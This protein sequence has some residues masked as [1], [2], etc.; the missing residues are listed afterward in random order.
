MLRGIDLFSGAGGLSMGMQAAGIN[1]VAAVEREQDAIRTL[2]NHLPEADLHRDDIRNIDLSRYKGAIDLVIG[3]PPC[4]PFSSGGLRAGANDERDMIPHFVQAVATLKPKAFLMENVRGLIVKERRH[5]FDDLLSDFFSLGYNV[6]WQILNAADYGVPQKRIRLFI[7]GLLQGSFSFPKPSHGLDRNFSYT[8]VQDALPLEQV[9]EPN[10]A[11]VTYA[12]T[13][14]VRPS[15]YH[16][17]LFNGG[18]RPLNREQP[19]PT[20]LASAGGNKTHFIDTENLVLPYHNHL[21]SGGSP[22]CGTLLG[23]RRLTIAES[24]I[25]QTFPRDFTFSGSKS[26]QY[27]QIGNAVPPDLARVLGQSLVSQLSE[28]IASA[29][30][31]TRVEFD[32]IQAS[33]FPAYNRCNVS[34]KQPQYLC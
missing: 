13:P 24:S 22:K 23:A 7:V 18:G 30:K 4:Q 33:L 16:G 15:P 27:T 6:T 28:E 3:G 10:C 11:K 5:Y 34:K 8:T 14:D 2:G 1:I 29:D 21:L 26:S 12:K 31:A 17:Q 25:L 32:Y 9:G 20:V 19:A